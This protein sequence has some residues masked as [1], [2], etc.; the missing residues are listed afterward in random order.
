MMATLTVK[1]ALLWCLISL[2]PVTLAQT[3]ELVCDVSV[4]YAMVDENTGELVFA[5]FP[6]DYVV[7]SEVEYDPGALGPWYN[8]AEGIINIV[9]PGSVTEGEKDGGCIA[10]Q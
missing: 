9:R 6:P 8:F 2:V 1:V 7:A 4:E 10:M 3:V 5:S